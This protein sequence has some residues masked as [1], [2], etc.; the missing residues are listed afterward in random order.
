MKTPCPK[1]FWRA[2]ATATAKYALGNGVTAVHTSSF[3]LALKSRTALAPLGSQREI[4]PAT[5][6]IGNEAI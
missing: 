6:V 1:E 2:P 5:D 4:E 3:M